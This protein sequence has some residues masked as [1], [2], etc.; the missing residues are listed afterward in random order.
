LLIKGLN[1]RISNKEILKDINI[2]IDRGI[3]LILGP[4]GS[5][6]TTLLRSIIGMI[7][8]SNGEV[9]VNEEK[10]YVPAEFFDVQMKVIDVLLSGGKYSIEKYK[11][12]IQFLN[13]EKYLN[14]DFSTLSTGEKKIVLIAKALSE[15]NLVIMDEPTSGLDMR[16]SVIIMKI[17]KD[18]KDKTFIITTHD[19]NT[20]RIA[21]NIILIKE[22]R[23]IFQGNPKDVDENLLSKLYE[24]PIKK[25]E[26]NGEI[27]FKAI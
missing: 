20:I 25:F 16:N 10:S 4:N 26:I 3:N 8:P 14:R 19:V 22:G 5:G 17:V 6:K 27:F 7:K 21:N 12:Y 18:I 1:V 11:K 23:V 24:I 2:E 15:G 13:I 9:V